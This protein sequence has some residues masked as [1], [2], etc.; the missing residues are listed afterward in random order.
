MTTLRSRLRVLALLMV[1]VTALTACGGGGGSSSS[2]SAKPE[3]TLAAAKKNLDATPGLRIALSTPHLP[4]GVSGLLGA[5]GI[6]THA[7]A[8]TGSIKVSASGITADAAVVAVDGVVYAK[9]PFTSSFTKI[10]P[11]DYSAP[12][13]AS[14]MQ[15]EGGLSSLLTSAQDVQEKGQVRAGKAVLTSYTATVPGK[16]VAA[17]IPSASP[18]ATFDATFTIDDQDQLAKAVLT[19]PFY[20]DAADVTYTITFTGYGTKQDITAP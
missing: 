20:P 17:V 2:S 12:D 19:G 15:P 5:K 6:A 18:T 11:A 16:D 1:L 10:N 9:L 14:L 8:F 4:P 3:D 7:P 13:P